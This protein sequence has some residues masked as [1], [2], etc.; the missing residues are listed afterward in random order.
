VVVAGDTGGAGVVVAG[1]GGVVVE[2]VVVRGGAV[3]LMAGRAVVGATVVTGVVGC[4]VVAGLGGAEV[5]IR[6][7][8]RATGR[9]DPHA[10]NVSSGRATPATSSAR[11]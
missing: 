1:R 8:F 5:S 9:V 6:R 11:R 4:A 7:I 3:V 2:V 10:A